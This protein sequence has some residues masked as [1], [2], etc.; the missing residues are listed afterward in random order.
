MRATS[1]G[2]V[3][4]Y[5]A[6]FVDGLLDRELLRSGATSA[7]ERLPLPGDELVPGPMWEATRAATIGA[8]EAEVWPWVAQMGYGRG[9]WYGWNPLEREDTGVS[10][11]L[12][13]L[14]PPRVGDVWLDGPGY[15]ETKEAWTVRAVD[16][17]HALVLQSIRDPIT[18]REL[19]LPESPRLFIDTAWAFHLAQLDSGG[20][21]LLARTRIRIAPRWAL[22]ALK[23]MTTGDTVMQRRLLD[24]IKTRV[25]TAAGGP[26]HPME[27]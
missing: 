4:E 17:P 7:E 13:D 2:G 23:W 15:H 16:P 1:V 5:A 10:S 3:F 6:Q 27:S 24:G 26:P 11:L 9:G 20:T 12:A 22:L 21:R 8:S 25:E 19:E 18:G 14:A